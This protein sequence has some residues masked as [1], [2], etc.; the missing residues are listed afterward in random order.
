MDGTKMAA[1]A[2]KYSYVWKKNA[3]RY[4]GQLKER[5]KKVLQEIDRVNAEDDRI[6]GEDSLEEL[7][8]GYIIVSEKL[9]EVVEGLNKKLEDK[10]Q[11]QKKRCWPAG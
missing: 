10:E 11:G 7:G 8:K 2:N 6:Y 5:V 3:D 1:D 9:E 4:K